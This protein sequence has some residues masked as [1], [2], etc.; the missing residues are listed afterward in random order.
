MPDYS[1]DAYCSVCNVRIFHVEDPIG[2]E[3][4]LYI[5]LNAP[6]T[7]F[8]LHE[9]HNTSESMNFNYTLE[10]TQLDDTN[11]KASISDRTT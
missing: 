4:R 6:K 1:V 2:E 11:T 3:R 8:C 9:E 7:V 5:E 10:W